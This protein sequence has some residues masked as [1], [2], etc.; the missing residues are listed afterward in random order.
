MRRIASLLGTRRRRAVAVAA[1]VVAVA[2]T[3][4]VVRPDAEGATATTATA[5]AT[6]ST[7]RDTVTGSG[8]L[9]PARS[10]T[11]SF[12]SSG[13]VTKVRVEAGDTVRKGAV[14]AAI[15]TTS[16]EAALT[17]AEAQLVAAQTTA[18]GDGSESAA[19]QAA[20]TARVASAQADVEEAQ[21]ALEAATLVAPFAGQVSAVGYEA[22]DRAGSS[23]S[24]G[25]SQ[26]GTGTTAASTTSTDGITVITPHRFVVTADVSAADVERISAGMQVEITPTGATEPVYGTVGTVGRVAETASDGT[27]TFPVTVEVTGRQADLH[28][29]T[30]A[31]VSIIVESRDDVLTV[32][33]A[34][35]TTQ[36]DT[37]YVEKVTDDGTER[38]EVEVGDTF[39]PTT[40]IVS[41]LDEGDTVQYEQAARAGRG[42]GSG[43]RGQLPEG[44]FPGGQL[45]DGVTPPAG[46]FPGAAG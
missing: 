25:A 20:N 37:T 15:D 38:V 26:P 18:S 28:A 41:G 23:A 14:L 11:L 30:S 44:G 46:G 36:D 45:P 29:G 12:A 19:Q 34:A 27:A 2:T 40:E 24:S 9:E 3:W 42:T 4:F 16:L 5:E 13:A 39:G 8:T 22:G 7:V 43:Q 31:D 1:V 6:T 33:T 10:A 32:P 21:D 35:V 17:S